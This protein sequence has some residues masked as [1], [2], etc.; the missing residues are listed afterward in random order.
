MFDWLQLLYA[1]CSSGPVPAY[2]REIAIVSN[3]AIALAYFWIPLVMAVVFTRWRH[4]LPFRWLWLGFAV[5]IVACGSSHVIHAGHAITA[6]TS[7]SL[8][9][10]IVMVATAAI[11]LATAV[12]FTFVLPKIL[13]YASPAATR[14]QLEDAVA[15]ATA[16]LQQALRHERVLLREIHHRVKNNLQV[17]ASLFSLHMRRASSEASAEMRALQHRIEAIAA[18]HSQ[19]QNVGASALEAR[20]FIQ[21]LVRSLTR[22][23]GRSDIELYVT[24]GDFEVPLDHA[25]S[26]ALILHEVLSNAL[27]HGF[28]S[29]RSGAVHVVLEAIE[30]QRKVVITDNGAGMPAEA[31]AGIGE[32]LVRTLA[33]QLGA[34]VEWLRRSEGGTVFTMTFV[35]QNVLDRL[36]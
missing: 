33:V 10:L 31:P 26:F 36:R 35:Q 23:L 18:V 16:D 25:T 15:A 28:P 3:L 24:G 5:F 12:A 17:I 13:R 29:E 22:S 8:G 30:T 14:R 9:A 32:T 11:S 21:L 7:H 34:S 19:L 6:K 2:W 1:I 20:A 27:R 4:E